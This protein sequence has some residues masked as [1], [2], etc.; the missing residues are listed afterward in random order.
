MYLLIFLELVVLYAVFW[1]VFLR[2]PKTRQI[3]GSLWGSYAEDNQAEYD[4]SISEPQTLVGPQFSTHLDTIPSPKERSSVQ[5]F[6]GKLN[7]ALDSVSI[8]TP[9]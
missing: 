1:A 2:E 3:K 6:L 4:K 9:R 7:N 8:K 5:G